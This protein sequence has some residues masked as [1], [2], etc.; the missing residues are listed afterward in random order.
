V[1]VRVDTGNG[2]FVVDDWVELWGCIWRAVARGVYMNHGRTGKCS[3]GCTFMDCVY[4]I[5]ECF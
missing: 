4:C 1:S 5:H 2:D 3:C